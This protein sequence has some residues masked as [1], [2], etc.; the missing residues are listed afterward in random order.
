MKIKLDT[1]L[2]KAKK[3]LF[4]NREMR[5]DG[6]VDVITP[7]KG[8]KILLNGF[9]IVCI[10]HYHPFTDSDGDKSEGGTMVIYGDGP[11]DIFNSHPYYD[12]YNFDAPALPWSLVKVII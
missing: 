5:G 6:P 2:K 1:F 11:S 7:K 3:H 10:M 8:Y 12:E 9:E 4:I